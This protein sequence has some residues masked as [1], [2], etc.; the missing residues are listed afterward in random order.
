M[1][2]IDEIMFIP[3]EFPAGVKMIFATEQPPLGWTRVTDFN[4]RVV[5]IVS[6]SLVNAG[7]SWVVTG[8]SVPNH[9]HDV[10]ISGEG[11]GGTI[12]ASGH[13][14]FGA[15]STSFLGAA[16]DVKGHDSVLTSLTGFGGAGAVTSD[17][18]W[19]PPSFDV[20]LACKD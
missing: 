9:K 20:I 15:G 13:P 19:R 14:V 5:R 2:K 17:G 10:A 6:G 8:L 18:S 12:W 7:T 3:S 11:S 4:D 16:V 1:R